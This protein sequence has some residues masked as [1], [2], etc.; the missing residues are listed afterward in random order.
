MRHSFNII[1]SAFFV[2]FVCEACGNV[3]DFPDLVA[4]QSNNEKDTTTAVIDTTAISDS[5]TIAIDETPLASE[6]EKTLVPADSGMYKDFLANFLYNDEDGTWDDGTFDATTQQW[7]KGVKTLT[8]TFSAS[9]VSYTYASKKGKE[10]TPGAEDFTITKSGA[11]ITITAHTKCNYI[12]QGETSNGSF[13]LYTDSKCIVTLNGVT[14]TNPYGAAINIQKGNDGGKRMFLVVANDTKNYLTDG[15]SYT[16]KYYPGTSEEEDEKGVIFSEG[17]I[18]V[19]GGGYLSVTGQ[20]KNAVACDDYIYLHKGP[21]LTLK[22]FTNYDGIKAKD[23]IYIGGGVLNIVCNGDNSKGLNT[24][25]LLW[26]NGGRTII[27]GAGT[28]LKYGQKNIISGTLR[29]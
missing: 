25:S 8:I 29:H 22:P 18:C 6:Y 2:I 7:T 1:V 11:N 23:G 5:D 28:A 14:L 12:L 13:K 19:S 10:G 21:Q 17:K 20:G 26:V 3:N 4:T 27:V 9:D 15:A 24:D 16:T